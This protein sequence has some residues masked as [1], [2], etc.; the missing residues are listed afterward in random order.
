MDNSYSGKYSLSDFTINKDNVEVKETLFKN[1]E[2]IFQDITLKISERDKLQNT[3]SFN[4]TISYFYS[5]FDDK[6]KYLEDIQK[7][8]SKLLVLNNLYIYYCN[9]IPVL[10][11]E[12]ITKKISN[13]VSSLQNNN[14]ANELKKFIIEEE[15]F[16]ITP[17]SE[18][19]K[20]YKEKFNFILDKYIK[21][22]PAVNITKL[23]NFSVKI[24]SWA[25]KYICQLFKLE[26]KDFNPKIIYYGSV[27][28]HESYFLILL[29]ML[30]CDLLILDTAG[31][32]EWTKVD[33]SKEYAVILE[34]KIKE[35]ISEN[36]FKNNK[37]YFNDKSSKIENISNAGCAVYT[38]LRKT[39]NIFE[40]IKL[41]VE[42]RGGHKDSDNCQIPVFFYR[43]IG[44]NKSEINK[45]EYNNSLYLLDKELQAGK[46]NYVKFI[47]QIDPP[48][49][50]EVNKFVNLVGN[51]FNNVITLDKKL[52]FTEI[53]N[54]KLF[55]KLLNKSISNSIEYAFEKVMGM[56]LKNE[57]T[58]TTKVKNFIV[59]LIVWINRY[60]KELFKN[61][62]IKGFFNYNPKILYY[63]EI[64]YTEVYLL[65]FF[66]M[67][68]CDVIYINSDYDK[69]DEFI[70]IDKEEKYTKLQK[71]PYSFECESFPTEEKLV[72]KATVAYNASNEVEKLLFTPDSGI[73]KSW[74]FENFNTL[75]VTLKTTFEEI[76][77]LW[78]EEAMI[79]TG[80]KISN[81]TVY[82]PNIFAKIDGTHEDV[83]EYRNYISKLRS[84]KNTYFI[85]KPNFLNISF[86]REQ[87][88]SFAYLI[89]KDGAICKEDLIKSKLYRYSYLKEST[90]N[91]I[92]KKINE[93]IKCGY[94]LNSIDNKFIVRIVAVLLNL[95]EE[96]L[97]LIQ[98]FDFP[99][100]IP[101]VI[102]YTNDK[103]DFSEEDIIT[104]LF[105]NLIGLDILILAPTGYSNIEN[106]VENSIF[107]KHELPSYK[108][109][110]NIN[111]IEEKK[112]L[113]FLFSK[114]FKHN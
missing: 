42:K 89:N 54:N 45:E 100:A 114:I 26:I 34:G 30:G 1:S 22:E 67:I 71:N 99:H 4:K 29:N 103:N 85:D 61:A 109:D 41:N 49:S 27:K 102:I 81:N 82:I 97:D 8:H 17:I 88:F 9:S 78:K 12:E 113:K 107:D 35:D 76:A 90:Q 91:L 14:Q 24:L 95:N 23:K 94:I 104:I 111:E 3:G 39:E 108:F 87:I 52:I 106:H 6:K 98:K 38:S 48:K 80:F 5:G 62:P 64:K 46:C 59:K 44:A 63:G 65:I 31:K 72:R 75:P 70:R 32:S 53:K 56:Y 73:Y 68:G 21:E 10:A 43:Y 110:L 16:N 84:A 2:N 18:I 60:S 74:Q 40:D 101:K 20:E 36:P 83:C 37:E 69:D 19:N 55:P 66:S 33:R 51:I 86:T 77:I 7:L 57:N 50:D 58:N 79:R 28:K 105:L 25:K 13:L 96:I 11:D 93:V 15:F 47:S 92:I 112:E